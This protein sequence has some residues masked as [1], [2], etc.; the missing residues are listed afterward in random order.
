[1]CCS[2]IVY[3]CGCEPTSSPVV[4][5]A[6]DMTWK[7]DVWAK[8][9]VVSGKTVREKQETSYLSDLLDRVKKFT[10]GQSAHGRLVEQ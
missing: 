7:T 8:A 5:N 1:M 4:A 3:G 6:G 9:K 10:P 2:L